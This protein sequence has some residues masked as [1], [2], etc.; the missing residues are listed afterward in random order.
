MHRLSTFLTIAL[1]LSLAFATPTY[2]KK[3]S[4][5]VDRVANPNYKPDGPAA[6]RWALSKFGFNNI[7]FSGDKVA[8]YTK[9]TTAATLNS[10]SDK[11]GQT[12]ALPSQNNAQFLSP[13]TIGR[14]QFIMNFDTGSSDM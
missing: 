2:Q 11:D 3:Q 1:F 4:F 14:Q 12:P 5:K 7:S 10:T 13:V 8:L 9:D 6:Y